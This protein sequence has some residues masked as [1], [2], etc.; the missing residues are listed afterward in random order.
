MLTPGTVVAFLSFRNLVFKTL[1]CER[2]NLRIFIM[3]RSQAK[4]LNTEFLKQ[5]LVVAEVLDSLTPNIAV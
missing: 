5:P 4:L 3:K 2:F 1:Y